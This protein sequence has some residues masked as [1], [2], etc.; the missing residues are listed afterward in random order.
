MAPQSMRGSDGSYIGWGVALG[1]Y[2][3]IIV[4]AIA[5]LE[6][7]ADGEVRLSIGGHEMGQ[8]IRTAL[9]NAVG[10]KLGVNPAQVVTGY[11][12]HARRSTASDRRLLGDGIGSSDRQLMPPT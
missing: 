5:Q 12:R 11:R 10:R 9:V 8:G 4:P 7:T 3:G 6:V 1:T 2:P